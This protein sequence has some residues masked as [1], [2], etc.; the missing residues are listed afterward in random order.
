MTCM[1]TAN[2]NGNEPLIDRKMLVKAIFVKLQGQFV[3]RR[4]LACDTA[5]SQFT[6]F[7]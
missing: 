3:L 7:R 4:S 6:F 2:N 1:E 5:G